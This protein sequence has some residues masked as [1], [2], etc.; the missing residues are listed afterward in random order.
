MSENTY[1]IAVFA[2]DGVGP[3]V[4]AEARRVLTAVGAGIGHTFDFVDLLIGGIAI[5]A[6]GTALR[7]EDV[8]TARGADAILLGAVGGPK[9][10]NP[11]ASVRPEQGLLKI[12]KALGL[13][14]NL[15]PVTVTESLADASPIKADRLLGTDLIVVRELTGGLYFGEPSKQW[16]ENGERV[17]V[18][19]LIYHEHEIV[20]V[21]KLAFELA[22]GRKGKVT[23][24][25]KANVLSSSRLWRAIVTEIG[26]EY[27]DV[28]LEHVLVDAMTMK[29]IQ[30]PSAYDVIVT[31]NMFG[32]ILTD[33]ASVLGGSLGL[34]PS[35]S[36][37]AADANGKVLALYE[38]IHGTAPDIAGQQKANPAGMIL[39]AAMMLRTSFGL[40]DAAGSVERA[41]ADAIDA[42]IRTGDLGGTA[43]TSQFSDAVI[44]RLDA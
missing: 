28:A 7:D 15:R 5:D 3:E 40:E 24:V 4:M 38:P 25:D 11:T 41:V 16:E 13:Y 34:L 39:S 37:G 43:T 22:R 6:Y 21:V 17:A 2:G 26:K 36:I 31:E 8:D 35:A 30:S 27:G 18:D 42:G 9:W 12:R 14:A 19:T 23:S 32:D 29:L 1:R 20:R 44:A 10:D 33:E